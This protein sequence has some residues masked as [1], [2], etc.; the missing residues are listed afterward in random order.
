MEKKRF[1]GLFGLL[2]AALV[3]SSN[4]YAET[5]VNVVRAGTLSSVLK[6][7]EPQLKITGSINGSD[8]KYLR[9]L[10]V[11]GKVTSLDLG[12]VRI[13]S[14]GTAYYENYKT[15]ADVLGERMFFECSKL[16]YIVLPST[17]TA[18]GNCAFSN[19]GL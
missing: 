1:M 14:G 15:E 5:V 4:M 8:A 7:T 9:S 2:V 10:V 18:I 16:R 13:V 19:S 3:S 12:E 11:D 6:E 17:I